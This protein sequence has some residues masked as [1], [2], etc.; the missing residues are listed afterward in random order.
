MNFGII[1]L[2]LGKVSGEG[3]ELLPENE[4]GFGVLDSPMPAAHICTRN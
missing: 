3:F 1:R 4:K 2:H